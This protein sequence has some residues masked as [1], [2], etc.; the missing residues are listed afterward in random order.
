M[1]AENDFLNDGVSSLGSFDDPRNYPQQPAIQTFYV[2]SP[3]GEEKPQPGDVIY[4]PPIIDRSLLSTKPQPPEPQVI[5]LSRPPSSAVP[6]P[7]PPIR[8]LP[9]DGSNNQTTGGQTTTTATT[10]GQTTTTTTADDDLIFG[11]KPTT[12]LTGVGV[13]L[14]LFF[15]MGSEKEK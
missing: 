13:A 6:M 11:F 7:K 15:L 8:V 2:D 9:G 14:A 1:R 12:V 5:Y 3:N 4:S 10:G